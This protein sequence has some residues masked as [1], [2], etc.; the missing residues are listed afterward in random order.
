M[1]PASFI[2]LEEPLLTP[3]GK[4]DRKL[5]VAR[6]L[7]EKRRTHKHFHHLISSRRCW[8]FGRMY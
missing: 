5:L 3:N 2:R 6:D 4:V 8:R 1:T 7:T